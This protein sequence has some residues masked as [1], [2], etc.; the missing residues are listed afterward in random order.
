M[1][2]DELADQ[3]KACDGSA[4]CAFLAFVPV[5]D[6]APQTLARADEVIE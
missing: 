4:A 1:C 2:F 3:S 5:V 6:G